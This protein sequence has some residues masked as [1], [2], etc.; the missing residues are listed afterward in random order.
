MHILNLSATLHLFLIENSI[1]ETLIECYQMPG[2]LQGNVRN[3][4][5]S[6]TPIL[7]EA[8][9]RRLCK[10]YSYKL[11][12]GLYLNIHARYFELYSDLA[13]VNQ[14]FLDLRFY[15]SNFLGRIFSCL[16]FPFEIT[17]ANVKFATVNQDCSRDVLTCRKGRQGT[18]LKR[19]S[20]SVLKSQDLEE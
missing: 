2:F 10:I 6:C 20:L 11:K 9:L 12:R 14:H 15:D 8:P 17:R 1:Q 19:T 16:F 13:L 7:Q 18:S 4:M 3:M 5:N